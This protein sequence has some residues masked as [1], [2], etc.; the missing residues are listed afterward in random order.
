MYEN[1][2]FPFHL[3]FQIKHSQENP[4]KPLT[5][6]GE[7]TFSCVKSLIFVDIACSQSVHS[8]AEQN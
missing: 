1:D 6:R 2:R 8:A 7:L 4:T 3:H 5:F